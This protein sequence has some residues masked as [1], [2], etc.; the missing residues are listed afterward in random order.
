[1]K[2]DV[3]LD[4]GRRLPWVTPEM[5]EEDCSNTETGNPN[6]MAF[7]GSWYYS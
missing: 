4:A 5:V 3:Q 1:M 7:D 2:D 6:P